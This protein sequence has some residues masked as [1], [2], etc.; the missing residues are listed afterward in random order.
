[1][2]Q[3]IKEIRTITITDKGQICIP[4]EARDIAGF[5]EGSKVSLIVYPDRV[6]IRSMKK[7]SDV[8][9]AMLASEDVL[10]KSWMSKE[11]DEAWKDL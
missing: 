6:E 10:A 5:Q 7:I 11:D 8:M 9:F 4:R 3:Q 1:M 2:E